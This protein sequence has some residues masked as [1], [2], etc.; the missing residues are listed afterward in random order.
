MLSLERIGLR[1]KFGVLEYMKP[2]TGES[3]RFKVQLN[4]ELRNRTLNAVEAVKGLMNGQKPIPTDNRNK[5]ENC[6][7]EDQCP[8]SLITNWERL[9]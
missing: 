7:Y 6:R 4:E 9:N 2:T 3:K 5:C 1:P 8:W